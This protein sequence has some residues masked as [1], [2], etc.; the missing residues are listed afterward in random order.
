M[1]SSDLNHRMPQNLQ[2]YGHDMATWFLDE[3]WAVE[4]QQPP[5]VPVSKLYM[6]SLGE[7]AHLNHVTTNDDASSSKRS[8][9]PPP[10]FPAS[11]ESFGIALA[12]PSAT[13]MPFSNIDAPSG[14]DTMCTTQADPT[15]EREAKVMRYKEKRKR[16]KYA[17]QIRYAARKAYAE[18]R[19]R[20]RGR[21]VKI[22]ETSEPTPTP[23]SPRYD[24][25]KLN[26]GWCNY[27]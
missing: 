18:V 19:P 27:W 3:P 1:S 20:I 26:L 8:F 10:T 13:S 2:F 7:S 16:R 21:F 11:T 14:S 15:T 5:P 25:N 4:P 24:P 23:E 22:P 9:A 17:K 12:A 6:S